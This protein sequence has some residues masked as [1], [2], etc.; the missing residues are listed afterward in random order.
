MQLIDTL[1]TC[2]RHVGSF[3]EAPDL[4]AIRSLPTCILKVLKDTF[5]HCKVCLLQLMIW[6]EVVI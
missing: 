4:D 3:E 6:K 2:V 1:F 5:Q